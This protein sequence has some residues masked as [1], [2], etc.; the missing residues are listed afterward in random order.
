MQDNTAIKETYIDLEYRKW[1]DFKAVCKSCIVQ[2]A[3]HYCTF[4]DQPC[5]HDECR[6]WAW[7]KFFEGRRF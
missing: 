1:L 6:P 5:E 3:R 4:S 7:H 2:H